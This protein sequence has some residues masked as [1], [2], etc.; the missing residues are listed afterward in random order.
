M[1]QIILELHHENQTKVNFYINVFK[2]TFVINL[3]NIPTALVL[4]RDEK[5][6]Y[7]SV[8]NCIQ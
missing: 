1:E 6:I 4:F 3:L 8:R 5:I 7:V 2:Y